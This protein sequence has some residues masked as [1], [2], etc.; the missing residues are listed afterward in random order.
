MIKVVEIDSEVEKKIVTGAIVSDY[1]CQQIFKMYKP[2]Y[3]EVK[4]IPKVMKWIKTYYDRHKAAP[5]ETIQDI[6][7]IAN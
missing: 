1:F 5:R 7:E 6:Y 2:E 4:Y 3:F